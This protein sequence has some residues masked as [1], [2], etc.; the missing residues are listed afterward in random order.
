MTGI[1]YISTKEVAEIL[2]L[3]C[4]VFQPLFLYL[5]LCYSRTSYSQ[6]EGIKWQNIITTIN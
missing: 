5:K 2:G 4:S 6:S 1:R 3:F